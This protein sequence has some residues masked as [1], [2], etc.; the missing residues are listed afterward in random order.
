[1]PALKELARSN[2]TLT[3]ARVVAAQAA[4]VDDMDKFLASRKFTRPQ[5]A[6]IKAA[7]ETDEGYKLCDAA[8]IWNAVTGITAYARGKVYQDERVA[9]EREA[10]RILQAA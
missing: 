1:V 10:G 3:E 9:I 5:I 8:T 7:F 4:R 2:V 6:G